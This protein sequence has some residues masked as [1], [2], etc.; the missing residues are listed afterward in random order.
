M[1]KI[2]EIILGFI[3]LL[4]FII[5]LIFWGIA[6]YLLKSLIQSGI[7]FFLKTLKIKTSFN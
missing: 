2:S 4:T 3:A 5:V 6:F 1:E 7:M